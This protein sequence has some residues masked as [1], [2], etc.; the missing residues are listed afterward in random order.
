MFKL[1]LKTRPTS[2]KKT[3][4]KFL[5][6]L[7]ILQNSVKVQPSLIIPKAYIQSTYFLV[8]GI[9]PIHKSGSKDKNKNCKPIQPEDIL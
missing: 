3:W 4:N 5:E 2:L 7:A 9:F 8:K 1:I 6:I